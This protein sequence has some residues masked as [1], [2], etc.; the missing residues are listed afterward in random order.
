MAPPLPA[1]RKKVQIG[2][3]NYYF[4][5]K[6]RL[7]DKCTCPK[8]RLVQREAHRV[9][10]C[11][12]IYCKSC[13]DDLKRKRKNCP[14]C[15]SSLYGE[16]KYFPDNKMIKMIDNFAIYCNN[17]D[18]GCH[19]KGHLK[20]FEKNH[21]PKCSYQTFGCSNNCG[22]NLQRRELDRHL[23]QVCPRRQFTCPFCKTCGE[24]RNITG[25][26]IT[27]C[28]D[29][30]LECPNAGCDERIK[31][32]QMVQHRNECPK[33]I[34]PCHHSSIGCNI[35]IKREELL[36][37]DQECMSF[38][39]QRAVEDIHRLKCDLESAKQE[40]HELRRDKEHMSIDLKQEICKLKA[41]T[42]KIPVI[43]MPNYSRKKKN[44]TSPDFY[45][46]TD[47]YKMALKV[48]TSKWLFKEYIY[49]YLALLPG[50]YDDTLEWPFQGEVTV[51][52]LNQLEDRGHS[53]KTIH[54]NKDTPEECK[55]KVARSRRV[56][57][58][59]T[60]IWWVKKLLLIQILLIHILVIMILFILE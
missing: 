60:V 25:D 13:L 31:R 12:K 8:C 18:K 33:E 46:S 4:A 14:N 30:I 55:N 10:C 23:K 7:L 49:C 56:A 20:D 43:K 37:H 32:C 40:I 27:T 53:K 9:K 52:L 6:K 35:M 44:W 50:E 2:G 3:Y 54:F 11:G 22:E 51:E 5:D 19:W 29:Y 17:N 41:Q 58:R 48:T 45:V 28:P 47:S 36:S 21:L 15:R 39:L 38:C 16:N 24:H 57:A 26:H 34:V 59:L 1:P 42:F